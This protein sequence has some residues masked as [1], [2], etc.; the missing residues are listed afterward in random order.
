MF[1]YLAAQ[2][3]NNIFEE[4]MK[5]DRYK[6]IWKQVKPLIRGRLLY[7]PVNPLTTKIVAA[8]NKTFSELAE[9][10]KF[11]QDW[12]RESPDIYEYMSNN[13]RIDNLRVSFIFENTCHN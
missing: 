6:V 8:A 11:A 10:K 13:S 12:L 7:T 5:D 1:V 3:C 9:W 2:F 4:L